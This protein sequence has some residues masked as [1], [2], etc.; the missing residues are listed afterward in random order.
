MV[1]SASDAAPPAQTVAPSNLSPRPSLADVAIQTLAAMRIHRSDSQWFSLAGF[2]LVGVL[3]AGVLMAGC[4]SSESTKKESPSPNV[5]TTKSVPDPRDTG[6]TSD[7]VEQREVEE[8]PEPRKV[9]RRPK[10]QKRIEDVADDWMGVP[11]EWGGSSK[12]GID[13]SALVQ[14]IYQEAFDWRLPRVTELQV[15]AGSTVTRPQ[16]RPGDLV[17]FRPDDDGNHVGLYV[18]EGDFI[19]ASVSEGVARE[20]LDTDYWRRWYWTSRRVIEPSNLPDTLA[21]QLVAYRYPTGTVTSPDTVTRAPVAESIVDDSRDGQQKDSVAAKEIATVDTT[22]IAD[23]EN[24]QTRGRQTGGR[25]TR[26]GRIENGENRV[27]RADSTAIPSCSDP[28]VQCSAKGEGAFSQTTFAPP[29]T[30]ERKG[31]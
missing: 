27:P 23:A 15:R 14:T 22:A 24:G 12:Q 18:G 29:D 8:R 11:Y 16:L 26:D 1:C 4:A 31:W 21:S 20:P 25:Q 17:F 19:H 28:N 7:Q 2:P 6:S 10:V 30:T 9:L 5:D 3:L 13:C